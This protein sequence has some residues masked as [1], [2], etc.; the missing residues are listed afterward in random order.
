M[1]IEGVYV[2][3]YAYIHTYIHTCMH[4]LWQVLEE[5]LGLIERVIGGGAE[6]LRL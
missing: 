5:K 4:A 6:L 3:V 2:L 1:R